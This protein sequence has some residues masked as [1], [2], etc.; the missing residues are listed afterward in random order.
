M[1]SSRATVINP[2]TAR[3]PRDDE[4]DVYGLTHPG[5]S[6]R[7]TRITSSICSLRASRRPVRPACRI[8]VSGGSPNGWRSWPWW[9]MASAAAQGRGGEPAGGGVRHP[10]RGARACAATTRPT[11]ATSTNSPSAL[12]EAA[13]NR[14]A[15]RTLRTGEA[16]AEHRG[17]ATTLT[18]WL[19]VWPRA[20]L[21]QVG[22]SRCYLLREGVLTQLSRD[23]TMA[24]ELV[25]L[26]V[27]TRAGRRHPLAHTL[28]SSIGGRQSVPVVTR[29]GTSWG[30]VGC[31]AA[32]A[33]PATS[34]TAGSGTGSGS[35]TSA[36]RCA[37]PSCRMRWT[38]AGSDNI[39][40]IVGRPV[41]RP[42]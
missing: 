7:R 20:Y 19:G 27:L 25:D 17:M 6:A 35:M 13:L 15:T 39:T 21:L 41:R 2:A 30:K 11:P 22:D 5:E 32:T 29:I 8:R 33:L 14:R 24:Q 38:A 36:V 42:A 40:I 23:Q 37:K 1:T 34:P 4:I 10:L 16:D 12:A 9:P 26:G 3:K 31:S 28:S 18:L